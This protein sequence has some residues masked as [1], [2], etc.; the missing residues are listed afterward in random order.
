MADKKPFIAARLR[1]P[2]EEAAPKKKAKSQV[3]WIGGACAIVA[4]ALAVAT[5]A[6]LYLDFNTYTTFIGK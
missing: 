5:V 1:N 3:D 4:F 2:T 6:F